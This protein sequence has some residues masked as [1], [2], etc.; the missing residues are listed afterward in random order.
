[1]HVALALLSVQNPRRVEKLA[2]YLSEKAGAKLLATAQTA[3]FLRERGL[4][5]TDT[6]GLCSS[7]TDADPTVRAPTGEAID[8]VVVELPTPLGRTP[9]REGF[10]LLAS[11]M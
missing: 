11:Q 1:M 2:R 9:P 5:V 10:D 4:P 7:G 6:S 8:L 3:A